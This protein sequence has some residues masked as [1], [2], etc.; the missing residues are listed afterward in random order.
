MVR[1]DFDILAG[2]NGGEGLSPLFAVTSGGQV[3]TILRSG[4]K[5]GPV[6]IKATYFHDTNVNTSIGQI[7]IQ[8]GPPVGE[9]FGISSG[10]KNI[11]GLKITGLENAIGVD[12]GDFAGN[13]VPDG[14]A[15]SFK[16]SLIFEE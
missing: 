7:A 16:T 12:V 11:S 4:F 2:P 14:T 1:I 6:N 3:S 13:P 5:S 15:I 9:E 8:N 10:F